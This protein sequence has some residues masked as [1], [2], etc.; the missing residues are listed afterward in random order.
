MKTEKIKLNNFWLPLALDALTFARENKTTSNYEAFCKKQPRSRQG[1]LLDRL[2]I[3]KHLV[4]ENYIIIDKEKMSLNPNPSLQ[5]LDSQLME[6]DVSAW[7]FLKSLGF[8]NKLAKKYNDENKKIIGDKGE[9]F[10]LRRLHNFFPTDRHHEIQHI[11]LLDDGAGYDIECPNLNMLGGKSFL[12]VKTTSIPGQEFTFYLSRN[13]YE[14]ALDKADEWLI[15]LIRLVN[16]EPKFFG[17]LKYDFIDSRYPKENTASVVSW[18][19]LK[20]TVV[21]ELV[22]D[23]EI[24]EGDM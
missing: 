1:S 23:L 15:I 24:F 16:G 8:K 19:N 9:K 5:W 2:K 3:Y 22:E 10:V 13:E 20:V 18:E 6:G 17:K 14:V 12:E 4:E 7:T 11:S 21:D